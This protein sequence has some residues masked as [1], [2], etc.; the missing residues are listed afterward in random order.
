MEKCPTCGE[1]LQDDAKFCGACGRGILQPAGKDASPASDPTARS[2]HPGSLIKIMLGALLGVILVAGSIWG[3]KSYG[4]EA[5]VES[6]LDLAVKYL[7]ENKYEEAVLAFNEV[8]EIDPK[9]VKGYQGLART[10]TL[11][12]KYDDAQVAYEKGIN[13]VSSNNKQILQLGLAGMYIDQ[14]KLSE[15]EKAFEALKN[16]NQNCLEAYWGLAM[17]YQQNGDNSKAEAMLKQ[18]IE[19]NLNE[20]RAYNTLALFLKQNNQT[21][22]AFNNLVKSLSLE[23]NQQEAYLVLNDMYQGRWT[24][25]LAGTSGITNQLVAS[26]LEFYSYYVSEDYVKALNIYQEK[27]ASESNNQKSRILAAIVMFKTGDKAGAKSLI[28][29]LTKEKL[30]EC[31]MVD[32][33]HYFFIIGDEKMA[34]RWASKSMALNGQSIEAINML[35]K[36]YALDDPELTKILNTKYMIFSWKPLKPT[37]ITDAVHLNG[38]NTSP[39]AK[40]NPDIS[41]VPIEQSATTVK[42]RLQYNHQLDE[43]FCIIIANNPSNAAQRVKTLLAQRA[44]PN[45]S[46]MGISALHL[47]VDTGKIEIVKDLLNA[48]ANVNVA[49]SATEGATPLMR[50]ASQGELEIMNILLEAGAVTNKTAA[51]GETLLMKGVKSGNIDVVKTIIALGVDLNIRDVSGKTALDHANYLSNLVSDKIKAQNYANI[52]EV[53]RQ[54]GAK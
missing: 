22:E 50:A 37:K 34:L 32:M 5:Q 18:A 48:G 1:T 17:V 10:Y 39:P 14:N 4:S 11:Q 46:L 16:T 31:I 6:K 27:L 44:D 45:A 33:S 2:K 26:M 23:I 19:Q 28:E 54:H 20:Y 49:G 47:A 12:E 43:Q 9:E 3:W 52:A 36:M 21:D 38:S 15:A 30:N 42:P 53:L 13:T 7:S 29:K 25:L 8:I 40:E 24:E 35:Y 41:S 51:L